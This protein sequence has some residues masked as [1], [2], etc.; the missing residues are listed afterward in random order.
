[1]K[2]LGYGKDDDESGFGF[3]DISLLTTP[4]LFRY[5]TTAL[6]DS[7]AFLFAIQHQYLP[8]IKE[9]ST[10]YLHSF[11]PDCFFQENFFFPCFLHSPLQQ[12][13]L[14]RSVAGTAATPDKRTKADDHTTGHRKT[15]P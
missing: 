5:I 11:F 9:L 7:S 4:G 3:Y 13:I 2:Y 14:P 1:M 10:N 12:E 8:A 6:H 15:K